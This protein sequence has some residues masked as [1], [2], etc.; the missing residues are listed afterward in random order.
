MPKSKRSKAS[1]STGHTTVPSSA[2]QKRATKRPAPRRRT[3]KMPQESPEVG[4]RIA[5]KKIG[6]PRREV[7]R[8]RKSE[9][10]K[11][12][13]IKERRKDVKH[14]EIYGV[15]PTLTRPVRRVDSPCGRRARRKAV[16]LAIGK[17][18]KPGG[19]PGPYRR[20]TISKDPCK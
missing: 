9:A 1:S 4:A 5:P 13:L 14:P 12:R 18:N 2:Q 19:A 16:L 17:V 20:T 8:Q 15:I 11:I 6:M 10:Y 7:Y 3:I